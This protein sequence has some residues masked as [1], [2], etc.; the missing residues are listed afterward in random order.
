METRPVALA[1][2]D[3]G[4][5]LR[6]QVDLGG[7]LALAHWR[8]FPNNRILYH[9][10]GHHTISLYLDGTVRRTDAGN[11]GVGSTGAICLVPA[12]GESAWHTLTDVQF[13][14]LYISRARFQR[15]ATEIF[16][17]DART[18]TL[19]D[20]SFV[21]DPLVAEIINRA[22][23]P[24]DWADRTN[25]LLLGQA[26]DLILTEVLRKNGPVRQS[27]L[28]V[29]GGLSPHVLRRI[30]DL[31]D[32]DL[33][34]DLSLDRLALEAG[35]SPYHFARMFKVSTGE[36]PHR[37]VQERRLTLARDRLRE[38]ARSITEIAMASGF[39]TPAHFAASFKARFGVSP[40]AL[41]A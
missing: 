22:I 7:G 17:R 11:T 41:R 10:P 36:T 39:S 8:N 21:A 27:G 35:L 4:A 2:S 18:L 24:N 26:A 14:H 20:K 5:E 15:L 19:P 38:G 33:A 32:A 9:D 37:F 30:R 29:A 31:I 23:L 12:E 28:A 34:G 3:A 1:L 25:R 13:C 40:S 6:R 16:D